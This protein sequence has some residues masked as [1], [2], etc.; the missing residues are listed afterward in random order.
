M[1][2]LGTVKK[3]KKK[4]EKVGEE[5][6][7]VKKIGVEKLEH[8]RRSERGI[9]RRI[10]GRTMGKKKDQRNPNIRV[11]IIWAPKMAWAKIAHSTPS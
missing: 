1:I 6:K 3:R 7:T 9:V 10:M 11:C 4:K 8:V 2:I 5:E